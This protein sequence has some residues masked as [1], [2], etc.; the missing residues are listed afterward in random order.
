MSISIKFT[1]RLLVPRLLIACFLMFAS[2][3][4]LAKEPDVNL[5]ACPIGESPIS[6]FLDAKTYDDHSVI[7]SVDYIITPNDDSVPIDTQ[8]VCEQTEY[9]ELCQVCVPNS[10]LDK[11]PTVTVVYYQNASGSGTKRVYSQCLVNDWYL[12]QNVI[13]GLEMEFDENTQ[14]NLTDPDCDTYT[15]N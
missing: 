13:Y 7:N 15:E 5:T 4:T 2:S 9:P 6:F 1:K 8:K 14:G 10:S 12:R 3:V 11:A